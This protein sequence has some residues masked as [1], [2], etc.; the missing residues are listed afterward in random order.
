MVTN[1]GRR[2]R[3]GRGGEG[4]GGE[5]RGALN[6][7]IKSLNAKSSCRLTKK[8]R[9]AGGRSVYSVT[10]AGSLMDGCSRTDTETEI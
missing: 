2:P 10:P 7:F 3:Q 4:R 5:G 9:L 6:M 8:K 1:R